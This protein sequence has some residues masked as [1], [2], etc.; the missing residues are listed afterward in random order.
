M[1]INLVIL[2][3]ILL[4]FL[5]QTEAMAGGGGGA[6]AK[7]EVEETKKDIENEKKRIEYAI[8]NLDVG[9]YQS[10]EIAMYKF[11]Q[12]AEDAVPYL[13]KEIRNKDISDRKL[14]NI[15]YVLGR[16]GS[17]A[18][19]SVPLLI[20]HLRHKNNDIRAVTTIALGKIGKGAKDAVPHLVKLQYDPSN[21]ISE[22]AQKA[23]QR[24][25]TKEAIKGFKDFK[26]A[27]KSN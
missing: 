16:I 6:S 18:K 10:S 17:K 19:A 2:V 25:K 22:S 14:S 23:L 3:L 20:P 11:E 13:V 15:I 26:M 27:V 5:F 24:I 21:W 9:D 8:N 12:M 7:A 1:R 4:I